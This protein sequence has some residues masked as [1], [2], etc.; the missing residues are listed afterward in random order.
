MAAVCLG[1]RLGQ[2]LTRVLASVDSSLTARPDREALSALLQSAV[3][4][5]PGFAG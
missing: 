4:S 2:G 1:G 3:P 5:P